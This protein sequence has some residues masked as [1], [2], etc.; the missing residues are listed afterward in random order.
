MQRSCLKFGHS[1]EVRVKQGFSFGNS[2]GYPEK[3]W[4]S[5]HDLVAGQRLHVPPVDGPI[6][7]RVA[8]RRQRAEGLGPGTGVGSAV[9]MQDAVG[10]QGDDWFHR[11]IMLTSTLFSI[12]RI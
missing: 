9:V 6:G 10:I 12:K 7:E 2:T 5:F 11:R 1:D 4:I 8:Q 3:L